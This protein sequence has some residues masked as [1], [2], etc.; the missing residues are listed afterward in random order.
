MRFTLYLLLLASMLG[1][2]STFASPLVTFSQESSGWLAISDFDDGDN[3]FTVSLSNLSGEWTIREVETDTHIKGQGPGVFDPSPVP[4]G[5]LSGDEIV[6]PPVTAT[7]FEGNYSL[8]HSLTST[9]G[10]EVVVNLGDV[11]SALTAG[12]QFDIA[13][14]GYGIG[15]DYAFL[16]FPFAFFAPD[17]TIAPYMVAGSISMVVDSVGANSLSMTVT[18]NTTAAALGGGGLINPFLVQ[19]LGIIDSGTSTAGL[20]DGT[21]W[22]GQNGGTYVPVPATLALFGLGAL[23][24]GATRRKV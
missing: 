2:S 3:E 15:L 10:N 8:A 1:V 21:F 6:I 14:N 12:D 7:I 13:L 11:A 18:D 4:G 9:S 17:K 16:G 23:M 19:Q 22:V 20:I 5:G 24:L